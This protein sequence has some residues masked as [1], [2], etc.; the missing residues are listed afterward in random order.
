MGA[1][2]TTDLPLPITKSDRARFVRESGAAKSR[3]AVEGAACRAWE[4]Y[5]SDPTAEKKAAAEAAQAN[6]SAMYGI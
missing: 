6:V 4:A 5:R 1:R 2:V 3:G